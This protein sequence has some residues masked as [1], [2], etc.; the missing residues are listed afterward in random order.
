MLPTIQVNIF[1]SLGMSHTITLV[2]NEFKLRGPLPTSMN[3]CG[4]GDGLLAY[5]LVNVPHYGL[6]SNVKT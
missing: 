1:P 5:N 4:F 2:C 6:G 3:V